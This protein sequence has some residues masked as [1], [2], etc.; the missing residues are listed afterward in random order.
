MVVWN[1][2]HGC[3][4]KSPGCAHCYVYRR[5]AQYDKD[6]RIV[7]QT[8]SFCLPVQK[9]RKGSWKLQGPGPI[10]TCMTSDFFIEEADAWRKE[11]WKFIQ[12]RQDLEFFIITKRIERF[13]VGLPADWGE[14]YGNVTVCATCENQK[15]ADERIP[16]L[17]EVPLQHRAV[18]HEPLLEEIN[19]FS[20]LLSGKIEQV[21]CGGES[22]EQ[23]RV[24]HYDWV[25]ALRR[26]CQ[27]NRVSFSFRQ[28]G[29]RFLKD[30]RLYS[31]PRKYQIT[32]AQKAL[33]DVHF[34]Q[35]K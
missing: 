12:I 27:I 17:L 1:P 34:E 16:I 14:G 22:G 19:I 11:A 29:A 3:Q 13:Y 32:Q 8:K 26:Q 6:S 25:L 10:Y 23:A 24:C 4:K 31:V 33:L 20:Y 18:I 2:W 30:G 35:K 28:T 21:I 15:M 5:D 7:T 9:N